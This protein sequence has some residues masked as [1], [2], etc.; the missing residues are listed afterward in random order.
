MTGV[1]ANV[2]SWLLLD[3]LAVPRTVSQ[4]SELGLAAPSRAAHELVVHFHAGHPCFFRNRMIGDGRPGGNH[5]FDV[6]IVFQVRGDGGGNDATLRMSDQCD[7]L[8]GF[9]AGLFHGF[10]AP[11]AHCPL[12]CVACCPNS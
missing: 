12:P 1:P 2:D 11:F 4:W 5:M 3:L 7:G 6:I 10:L 9:D 8:I